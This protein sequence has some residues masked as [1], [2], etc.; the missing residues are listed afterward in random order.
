MICG[1]PLSMDYVGEDY[2]LTV[3]EID[4]LVDKL[5]STNYD[6]KQLTIKIKS[7]KFQL[8]FFISE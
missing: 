7:G 1:T 2:A 8:L 4:A 5:K 3:Q 6:L